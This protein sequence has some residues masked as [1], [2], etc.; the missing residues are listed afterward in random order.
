MKEKFNFYYDGTPIQKSEF[1]KRVPN[2]WMEE[3]DEGGEYSW[4][5]Y[6]ASKIEEY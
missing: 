2:N 5:Y 4:G 1:L 3:L 6:R